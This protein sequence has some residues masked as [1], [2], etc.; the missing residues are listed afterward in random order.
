MTAS[1]IEHLR[2][3]LPGS[4]S[5]DRGALADRIVNEDMALDS[6]IGLL[7]EEERLANRFAWMLSGVAERAPE[8]LYAVL[9]EIFALRDRIQVR[10]WE[11]SFAKWWH[12]CGLPPK[13][14]TITMPFWIIMS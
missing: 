14:C 10:G 9:V 5:D 1:F 11:R 6:L 13:I 7:T 8:K 4:D 12:I 3:E 2:Q